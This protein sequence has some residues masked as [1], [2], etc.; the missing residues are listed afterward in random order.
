[1]ST[2]RIMAASTLMDLWH[3]LTGAIASAMVGIVSVFL[4][5]GGVVI[6]NV[7]LTSVTERTREIGIRKSLGAR[8]KDIL[9]QFVFEASIMA[10]LGGVIGVVFAESLGVLVR[11]TTSVPM[12]T[13][14]YAVLLAVFISTI[15]GLFFGIYPARK[16]ANL[17]PIEAMRQ[18]T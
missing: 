11:M 16:A 17:D 15:V 10:A 18:E 13:P 7:M 12:S 6:M 8:K 3:K 5:I 9:L 1:M 2:K 14:V 4:V